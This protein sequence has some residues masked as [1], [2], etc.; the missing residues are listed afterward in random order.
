MDI[1][2]VY[3]V[4]FKWT[5]RRR[6]AK[7]ERRF[8]PTDQTRIV[9]VGGTPINWWYISTK[10][11]LLLLNIKPPEQPM[12]SDHMRYVEGDA[13]DPPAEIRDG[14]CDIVFSNSVI[15]HVGDFAAQ[16]RF[17]EACR[18]LARKLWVQT[19]AFVFPIEPHYLSPF[20]Q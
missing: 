12:S 20:V 5:R 11:R 15:E 16:Q 9:D 19:P 2:K 8:R 6:M 10:P 4:I 18:K 3:A 17:A 1:H 13:C 14:G 7:F